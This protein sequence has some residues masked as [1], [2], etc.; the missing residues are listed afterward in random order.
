MTRDTSPCTPELD[1]ELYR[2]LRRMAR[3]RLRDGGRNTL[4]DT[5]A[6]VHEAWL[7]MAGAEVEDPARWMAYASRT[8]RSVIV[9]LARRRQTERHGGDALLVT[10]TEGLQLR[11]GAPADEVVRVHE[12]LTELEQLDRTLAMVVEM[13]YFAGLDDRQIGAALGVSDR[14]VRR[15]WDKARLLLGQALQG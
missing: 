15:H 13:R 1:A 10:W 14:T 8:M 3:A 11:A 9:D 5:S 4:L 2:R 6:L 12:A 7:R